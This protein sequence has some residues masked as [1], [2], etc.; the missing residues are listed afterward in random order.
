MAVA[1]PGSP[2][3]APH[4]LKPLFEVSARRPVSSRALTT[5]KNR[6]ASTRSSAREPTSSM[7]SSLGRVYRAS[8]A[9]KRFSCQA[10]RRSATRS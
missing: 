10:L 1:H 3:P 4:S 2:Q 8:R 6:C 5:R 7:H 9:G